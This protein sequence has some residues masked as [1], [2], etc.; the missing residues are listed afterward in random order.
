MGTKIKLLVDGQF[1]Q[2]VASVFIRNY[3][4]DKWHVKE[5]ARSYREADDEMKGWIW[6]D[7]LNEAYFVDNDGYKWN[8]YQDGDLFAVRQDY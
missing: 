6:D 7:I 5:R 4:M 8:L 3:D 2:Y 1:G